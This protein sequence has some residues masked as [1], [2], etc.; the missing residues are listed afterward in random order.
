MF[1]S[2][3]A[4]VR[5]TVRR[6]RGARAERAFA[7][8]L[9]QRAGR[10][11]PQSSGKRF[12]CQ[13]R[14]LI[15]R[16]D[17]STCVHGARTPMSR[18]IQLTAQSRVQQAVLTTPRCR[19]YPPT[20]PTPTPGAVRGGSLSSAHPTRTGPWRVRDH[21]LPATGVRFRRVRASCHPSAGRFRLGTRGRPRTTRSCTAS[22][23]STAA[24]ASVTTSSGASCTG[25]RARRA[26]WPR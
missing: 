8:P 13:A 22:D 19:G 10:P 5:C 16:R 1:H 24:T 2:R 14:K 4:T 15:N 23:S 21:R 17:R 12:A 25:A 20:A 26:P 11:S 6:L 9:L 18:S 3:R 7:H